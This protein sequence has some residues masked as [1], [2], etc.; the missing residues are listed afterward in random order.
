MPE[1]G[2]VMT[3]SD[4]SRRS[5]TLETVSFLPSRLVAIPRAPPKRAVVVGC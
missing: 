4:F 3:I 1:A 5:W 2:T